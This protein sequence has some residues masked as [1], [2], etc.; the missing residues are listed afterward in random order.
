MNTVKCVNIS[1]LTPRELERMLMFKLEEILR[2]TFPAEAITSRL[3]SGPDHGVDAIITVHIPDGPE[4]TLLMECKAQPRPS[5]ISPAPGPRMADFPAVA[6]ERKFERQKL[7]EVRAWVFAAPTISDRMADVCTDRGWSWIDLAGNCQVSVPGIL[8]IRHRGNPAVHN[9][10]RP[11]AN[12]GTPEAARVIRALLLPDHLSLHWTQRQLRELTE[13]NVSLGL[14]NKVVSHLRHEDHLDDLSDDGFRVKD[15][16]KLLTAWRNAY[17]FD[18]IRQHQWFTLLRSSQVTD[19]VRRHRLLVAWAAFSAAE[20]QAPMVTQP[21]MWLMASDDQVDAL[22]D[23]L[24]ATAVVSGANLAVLT[25]PDAGYLAHA[26]NSPMTGHCTH[27][28]QTYV[29]VWHAGGRGQEAAEAVL[30]QC[31]RPGWTKRRAP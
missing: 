25:P 26:T 5:L 7:K 4:L 1:E 3:I 2:T 15:P 22:R 14:V 23:A 11:D 10:P 9:G 27:P 18:R 21:R 29:D 30:T 13:P 24:D 6:V 17:R 20:R 12:L 16:E 19:A 28:L 31:L 8:S